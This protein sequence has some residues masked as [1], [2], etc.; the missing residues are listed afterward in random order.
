M[1][2]NLPSQG[3]QLHR[4]RAVWRK[5]KRAL[6]AM[7]CRRKA[8]NERAACRVIRYQKVTALDLAGSRVLGLCEIGS[9]QGP[10][11]E[12]PRC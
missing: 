7:P 6:T 10:D 1:P 5:A 12:R 3:R 8:R 4:G 11:A 2:S 9:Q